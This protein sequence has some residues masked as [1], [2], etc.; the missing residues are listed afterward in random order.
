MNEIDIV[1][2]VVGIENYAQP[3]WNIT[4]PYRNAVDISLYLLSIGTDPKKLF[5]FANQNRDLAISHVPSDELERLVAAGVTIDDPHRDTIDFR[6]KSLPDHAQM[7]SRLFFCL[8]RRICGRFSPWLMV[9]LL[10]LLLR[11]WAC[12]QRSCVV[13][14][15]IA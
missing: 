6:F 11:L 1:A 10:Y 12:G 3:D 9:W 4:G 14:M 7:P 13:H 8:L 2:I 15:S 5:L